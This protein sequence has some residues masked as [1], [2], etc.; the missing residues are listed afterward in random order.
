MRIVVSFFLFITLLVS[1]TLYCEDNSPDNMLT[2][3]QVSD[4]R[5]GIG[6][7]LVAMGPKPSEANT[8]RCWS[9]PWDQRIYCKTP[10][11]HPDCKWLLFS[12]DGPRPE[13]CCD[14]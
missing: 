3:P 8:C 11:S 2:Y 5:K 1:F 4:H 13:E 9:C 10:D 14:E 7:D 12:C 6:S